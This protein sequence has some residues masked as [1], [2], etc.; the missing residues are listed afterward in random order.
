MGRSVMDEVVATSSVTN[1]PLAVV[2]TASSVTVGHVE[3]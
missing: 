1:S 2:V 3:R